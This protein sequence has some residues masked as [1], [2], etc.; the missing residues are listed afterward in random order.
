MRLPKLTSRRWQRWSLRTKFAVAVVSVLLV[1]LLGFMAIVEHR[2]REAIIG[3]VQKRGMILTQ[4]LATM[5]RNSLL[6]YNY[7]ALE[8]NVEKFAKEVD[9]VYAIILEREGKVAAYSQHPEHVGLVLDGEIDRRAAEAISLLV[10]ETG[11]RKEAIYDMAAPVFVEGSSGKWGTVRIGLSKRRMEAEIARTRWE[12]LAL[13]GLTLVFGGVA[14]AWVATRI[15]RPLRQLSDAARAISEGDLDQK[16]DATTLDEIGTLALTFNH[17]AATL[18]QQRTDIERTHAELETS[19]KKL[20]DMKSYTDH[21]LGSMPTGILTIDRDGRIVTTNPALERLTGLSSSA[22]GRSVL[23]VLPDPQEI[24]G[25]L[26]ETLSTSASVTL[27]SL[28]M[29]RADGSSAQVEITTSSLLGSEGKILGVVGVFRDLSVIHQ[30]EE[31]LRRADR[32]AAVGTLAAGLA[33]EIKN[34]LVALRAYTQML[35]E[36]F[37]DETYRRKFLEIVPPELDRINGIIEG[38]LELSR[39]ARLLFQ[40]VSLCNLMDRILTLQSAQLDEK[41][42]TVVRDYTGDLPLINADPE[43]LYRALLNLATNAID[44]M[45]SHGRLT[46]RTGWVTSVSPTPLPLRAGPGP[47]VRVE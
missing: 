37:H 29:T 16:I 11:L 34:P 8:Q 40:P 9:V 23:E 21:I 6:L 22:R 7:T 18:L 45:A 41:Q 25:A 35:P 20:S 13:A 19:F 5:S 26:V 27:P 17:M 2:Q 14:S 15:A 12:L 4:N 32:L 10:Q 36:K 28:T 39:P 44:S 1:V 43:H 47:G 30:L 38:L 46:I 3:E 42:I 33:H 31:Q 24:A